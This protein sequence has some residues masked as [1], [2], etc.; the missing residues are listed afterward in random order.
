VHNH[1]SGDA[2]PSKHD[3]A[4]TREIAKAAKLLDIKL[5][6]CII[7]GDGSGTHYSFDV[8]GRIKR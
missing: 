3:T 4:I 7:T 6:D 1:P 8:A 2:R 5:H